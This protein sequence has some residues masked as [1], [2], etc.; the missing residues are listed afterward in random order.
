MADWYLDSNNASGTYDGTST[1]NAWT[2]I[3][4]PLAGADVWTSAPANSGGP[5]TTAGDIV[6]I[7]DTHAE[8]WDT[9]ALGRVICSGSNNPG[10]PVIYRGD[11][12][13]VKWADT[14]GRPSIDLGGGSSNA[15]FDFNT[16]DVHARFEHIDFT[17]TVGTS[18]F[19][20]NSE[21]IHFID[22]TFT[23]MPGNFNM[24]QG[25]TLIFED[26]TLDYSAY[27]GGTGS[28]GSVVSPNGIVIMRRCTISGI[29]YAFT[30]LTNRGS[31][32]LGEDLVFIGPVSGGST[33]FYGPSSYA[34][35]GAIVDGLNA[36][37]W[38][39]IANQVNLHAGSSIKIQDL[40]SP[41][42]YTQYDWNGT[43]AVS[44]TA[45][46]LHTG[47]ADTVIIATPNVNCAI[48]QGLRII[49]IPIWAPANVTRS[50]TLYVKGTGW[51]VNPTATEL[52]FEA[53]Y[54]ASAGSM[55]KTWVSSTDV[56]SGTAWTAL[57]ISG[58]TP[59]ENGRVILRLT[60]SK[61]EASSDIRVD[62]LPVRA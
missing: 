27:S 23:N 16:N 19:R 33:I 58:I 2:T 57:T 51:T 42:I 43:L 6:W 20:M 54:Y 44:E 40:S 25:G 15:Y 53:G 28:T 46:N 36:G 32:I 30:F 62:P 29:K 4:R 35:A 52:L 22:C 8:V 9:I 48:D 59:G 49:E 24:N 38:T 41:R 26:C 3:E 61:Y 45:G 12:D 37:S 1:A 11:I 17:N 18:I 56:I 34:D 39:V 14:G 7:R 50:Y 60:L 10:L 21:V 47:G 31:F 5:V 13:G 55:T